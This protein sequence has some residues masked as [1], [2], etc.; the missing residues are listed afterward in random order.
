MTGGDQS[1]V[2]SNELPEDD[3]HAGAKDLQALVDGA[4]RVLLVGMYAM[5]AWDSLLWGIITRLSS[6]SYRLIYGRNHMWP[7]SSVC[8]GADMA[9]HASEQLQNRAGGVQSRQSCARCPH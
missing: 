3:P 9:W 1:L 5:P 8:G 2:I 4:T 7:V 6:T